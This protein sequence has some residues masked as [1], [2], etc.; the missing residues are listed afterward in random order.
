MPQP[1]VTTARTPR[2]GLPHLFPGQAQK[3]AFVNEAL[4]RIDALVHLAVIEERADPPADPAP[5]DCYIVAAE[6][7]GAWAG[8]EGSIANWTETLW[9][10]AAP[11]EGMRAFDREHGSLAVYRGS[12]G[13]QRVSAPDSPAGGTMPDA[14]ARAAVSAVIDGLR[15]LGIFA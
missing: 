14:E 1:E 7:T 4:A 3:E 12:F 2:H 15:A 10:I 8:H 5:G 9:L 13:W 11:V 6:A